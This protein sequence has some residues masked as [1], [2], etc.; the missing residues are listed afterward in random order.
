[1]WIAYRS[2]EVGRT[3]EGPPPLRSSFKLAAFSLMRWGSREAGQS[4]GEL[5]Q[6]KTGSRRSAE[7]QC[8]EGLASARVF[9]AVEGVVERVAVGRRKALQEFV[10]VVF[11]GDRASEE[12]E[13]RCLA[14]LECGKESRRSFSTIVRKR[15][16]WPALR[17]LETERV[18]RG[19]RSRWTAEQAS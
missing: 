4:D 2:R 10:Y 7:S 13:L 3:A 6:K 8:Q 11:A 1:M 14:E 5:L 9:A 15:E 19:E 16:L 12:D 17:K 18:A